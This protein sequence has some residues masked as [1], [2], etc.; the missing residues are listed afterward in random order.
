VTVTDTPTDGSSDAISSNWAFDNVKTSVPVNAV[1][2]DTTYSAGTLLDISN[3]EFSVDLSELTDKTE[4]MPNTDEFVI[5]SGTSQ[6]RKQ[7][8]EI[9]LSIFN[10]DLTGLDANTLGG[11]S[12]T[13]YLNTDTN[14]SGE[15]QG[16]YN[17][18]TVPGKASLTGAEFTGAITVPEIA[19]KA[20]DNST[21]TATMIDGGTISFSGSSGQLFSITDSLTGTIFSVNDISGIPSIEVDDDGTI[22]FAEYAGNVL[23]GTGTDNGTHTLQV[24]G[25]ISSSTPATSTNDTTVA[26]TAYVK[27]NISDLIGGA[28]GALDTLNELAAALNDDASF[29]TTV[30]TA[31]GNRLRVDTD[32]QGL[33]ETQKANALTNLGT[34][35]SDISK[36][37]TAHGWGNHADAGYITS[38]VN[39][40]KA[41]TNNSEGY[42]ASGSGQVNKVW[43]TDASGNPAW[44][45]D[46]NDNTWKANSST[47]EGYV[48]SGSGQVNKVW[49]TDASGNPAW[50][51]D[52]NTW[53][54]ISS[55]PTD[56][57]TT[58]S[59]SSDWAF[60]NVKTSV[61]VNAVFTDTWNA[62]S[63]TVAGYVSAPGAVANKV[64]KTDANG[65]PGWRDDANTDTWNANSKTV[66]G[67]VS[68]P[69]AA[70]NKVWK[71][72]ASGNPGWRDDANTN[73]TYT[74]S[75]P[76]STTKIR[77]NGSDSSTDD[78]EIAGSGATTV[79]RT[80][81]SKLTISSTN[82]TYS[83]ATTNNSGLMSSTDKT[84][85]DNIDTNANNYSLPTATAEVLGG[86][87][88]G[89]NLSIN[90]SG[91]LSS[92]DTTYSAA[93]TNA[94]GLMS[95]TDK[96]KLDNI[97]TN[98]NNYSLPTATGS[99]L[100]G[101]KVGDRLTITNGV[102]SADEQSTSYTLPT[103]SSTTKGG[104]TVNGKG[105]EMSGTTLQLKNHSANF[106][107]ITA[108]VGTF[109]L[110]DTAVLDAD[111]VIA[112]KIQVYPTGGTAPDVSGTTIS[113]KGAVITQDGDVMIGDSGGKH[114]FF[115]ESEG[116]LEIADGSGDDRTE[117]DGG[118]IKVF[119][120]GVLRV[121]IG[122]LA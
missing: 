9:K 93:T 94:D 97:D 114:I 28:P 113:G 89:T 29:H 31:L 22:R 110:V 47:S 13:Y 112:R 88:V 67:Y 70:A 83:D 2:T 27:S 43:K 73:T 65:N 23:I 18:L 1:F 26:T 46:A 74:T 6:Y 116:T 38:Y 10:N 39:T 34:S 103:A 4:D 81:D 120:G 41:N 106:D 58:T 100:G 119:S 61:P 68:A 45:D 86:I 16:T 80:S 82:T 95:S 76:S 49:K 118:T 60:D 25:T 102:L 79:T 17:A 40:W 69:G 91:V 59:I 108:D 42:V 87:K 77:L 78:I 111:S 12:S 63:K 109:N 19:F 44:R 122:N 55:T 15:V 99:L 115:D 53:R 66:A 121:K 71:T 104:I 35:A 64:W 62:N 11:Q 90:T 117:F 96:T 105:L 84:K 3:N 51:D 75:I 30:T 8:S 36:G 52:A 33:S 85:L 20:T 57:A 7:A 37:V 92:T 50:R 101:I 14:F 98:A 72:D 54:P 56:G 107:T 24:E 32:S 48:A 21:I 5:L